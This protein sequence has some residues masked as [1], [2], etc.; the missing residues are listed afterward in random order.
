M[1]ALPIV[2]AAFATA[3]S[4][5]PAIADPAMQPPMNDFDFAFYTCDG[6]A[7]QI[8][9]DSDTPTTAKLTTSDRNKQYVLARK[10]AADG[11]QFSGAAARFWTDGKKVVVEGTATPL[12]NC[13]K[14]PN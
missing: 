6:G 4:A 8:A 12:R 14:K 1:K 7:F 9:Y 10:P 13:K 11:V 5:T 2:L 3:A